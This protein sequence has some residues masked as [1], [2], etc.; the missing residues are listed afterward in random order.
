MQRPN[1]QLEYGQSGRAETVPCGKPAVAACADCGIS[2]CS[3]CRVECCGESF[4][5]SRRAGVG[6][7]F[8]GRFWRSPPPTSGRTHRN[9]RAFRYAPAVSRRTLVACWMRRSD[10]PSRPRAKTCCFFSSFK[11][12]AMPTEAYKPPPASM[13][14][15]RC[16]RWSGDTHWP[17]LGDRASSAQG[18]ICRPGSCGS[19]RSSRVSRSRRASSSGCR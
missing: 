11:T 15:R 14:Q 12:L 19:C 7:H 17:V 8:V 9:P 2:V 16:S 5:H 6:D 18:R 13:S 3:D 4:D 1:C 10:Y